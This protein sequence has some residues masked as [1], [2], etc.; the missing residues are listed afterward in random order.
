MI[1]FSLINLP[2]SI[3]KYQTM[4][5]RLESFFNHH[6]LSARMFFSGTMC[7]NYHFAEDIGGGFLHLIRQGKLSV[8]SSAHPSIFIEQPSLL[9]YPKHTKH[10]FIF[11]GD[12]DLTCAHIDLDGG[13]DNILVKDLPKI[14]LIPLSNMPT[15]ASTLALLFD[16]AE[17]LNCG[18]QAAINR[19]FEYLLILLIRH[20]IDNN[21]AS[22][23]LLAG[24]G[25]MKLA[26]AITAMHNDPSFNWS[27]DLLA[28]RA[29]MSRARF[30]VHFREL[31]GTTPMSHLTKC[32]ISLAQILIKKGKPIGLVANEVGYSSSAVLTRIFKAHL[33]VSPKTWISLHR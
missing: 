16:E 4:A 23:G 9:L 25:D 33:G 18:R 20:I 7:N 2:L 22:Y 27:L 11:D 26:K 31:V 24:L 6:Q 32:R 15:M 21:Q 13:I 17:Q 10:Q 8:H 30:A 19:L 12:V 29:G 28:D 14:I 3:K 5:D 1:L